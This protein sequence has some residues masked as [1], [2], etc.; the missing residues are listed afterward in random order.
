MEFTNQELDRLLDDNFITYDY[1]ELTQM[2][3][4]RDMLRR[5]LVDYYDKGYKD[6]SAYV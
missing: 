5:V 3:V 1:F 4:V 6:G 2:M